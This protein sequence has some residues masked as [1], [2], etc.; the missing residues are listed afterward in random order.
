MHWQ[1]TFSSCLLKRLFVLIIFINYIF[2]HIT[3]L[4]HL[5][6]VFWCFSSF[7][8][9]TVPFKLLAFRSF[10]TFS[11]H[12]SPFYF[13][14]FILFSSEA[15]GAAMLSQTQL[16]HD[17]RWIISAKPACLPLS[18]LYKWQGTEIFKDICELPYLNGFISV[19]FHVTSFSSLHSTGYTS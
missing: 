2:R 11:S 15:G 8:L 4:Y 13:V 9:F 6:L 16:R 14:S 3:V 7:H 17:W 1:V 12:F 10:C 5:A 19:F 18:H